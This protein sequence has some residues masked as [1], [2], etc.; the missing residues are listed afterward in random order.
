MV[1]A[2]VRTFTFHGELQIVLGFQGAASHRDGLRE[3][4]IS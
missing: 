2:V 4:P 1:L 3:W